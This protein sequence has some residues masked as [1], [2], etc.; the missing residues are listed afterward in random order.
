L[1]AEVSSERDLL[2]SL[3]AFIR[4]GRGGEQFVTS[5][6][7]VK[8]VA[9]HFDTTMALGGTGVRAAIAMDK[10]GLTS[11]LYLVSIDDHVRQL[12]PERCDYICSAVEDRTDPHLIIHPVSPGRPNPR[13]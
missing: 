7:V 9:D 5:S 6:T 10:L 2:R 8:A 13:G 4:A 1:D 3:L 12:L 11:T